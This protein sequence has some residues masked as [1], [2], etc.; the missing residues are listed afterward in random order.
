MAINLSP[1]VR[2]PG[3]CGISRSFPR[4]S[5]TTG[6]VPTRYSPVRHSAPDRSREHAFDLHV[7]S[8]PPAFVLS[9]DQTLMFNPNKPAIH[10]T[11]AGPSSQGPCPAQKTGPHKG[12]QTLMTEMHPAPHASQPHR[13]KPHPVRATDSPPPPAHPFIPN[14]VNQ[15]SRTAKPRSRI[16]PP[17]DPPPREDAYM[18]P[19]PY[20][21]DPFKILAPSPHPSRSQKHDAPSRR[22]RSEQAQRAQFR[23]HPSRHRR[24]L[25]L[26]L[27]ACRLSGGASAGD[28]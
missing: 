2:S 24:V 19:P 11:T 22:S 1:D 26:L 28:R 16:T 27:R 18:A 4:L 5:P 8:M 14:N 23:H 17:G 20:R 9:Q 15:Q 3:L 10:L 21:Q 12:H 13:H 7:L 6:Q 25:R